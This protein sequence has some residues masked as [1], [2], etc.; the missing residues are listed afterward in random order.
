MN[1]V[2]QF[3]VGPLAW[4]AWT[5]FLGGSLVRLACM[6]RSAR[7][8]DPTVLEYMSFKYGM[9]SI[10]HWIIPFGAVSWRKH[11]S[12]TVAT[13]TFHILLF[14][15][16][17]FLLGHVVLWD[18]FFGFSWPTIPEWIADILSVVV[19]V[20][21]LY[22]ASRR[23]L[24]P[25]VSFVTRPMDW[26]VLGIVVMPFLTGFLAYHQFFNYELMLILHIVS[27]EIMLASIP[28]TRLNHMLFGLFSRAYMGSEFGAVRHAKDW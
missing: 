11:P 23:I 5:L 12:M 20:A 27:G 1:S 6:Y 24:R 4:A 13:F 21:C 22:F 17:I 2:Y 8:K 16:P 10:L 28:F 26:I 3:V 18:Q 14:V 9:R 15:V 7:K 25:E 19:V